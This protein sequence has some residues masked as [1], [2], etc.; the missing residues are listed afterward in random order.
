MSQPTPGSRSAFT[1][2]ELL[3][4][5]AIIATLVAI[6]LPAVQQAR[7]AARRSTCKNNLKQLGI[8]L[9]NYHD[10]YNTLPPGHVLD[11]FAGDDHGHWLWSAMILPFVEQSALYDTVRVGSPVTKAM[12]DSTRQMQQLLTVFRCPSDTGPPVFDPASRLGYTIDAIPTTGAT[13]NDI[14]VSLTNYA[15]SNGTAYPRAR[16]AT[17]Y[18][19]GTTGATG[20]FWENSRCKFSDITDGL[21]NTILVG[22]RAYLVK[23]DNMWGAMCL[24]IRGNLAA[25]NGPTAYDKSGNAAANQ[26]MFSYT[27]TTFFGINPIVSIFTGGTRD[28]ANSGYSSGHQGGAQFLLGDGAVIF[29]N[30]NIDNTGTGALPNG[31]TDSTFERLAAIQDGEVVGSF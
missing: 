3:V 23:G 22:E 25:G 20:A 13:L 27:G 31:I 8:A 29:L 10:T 9:H 26:G 11:P 19:N 24:A 17:N 16:K 2:I 4:V 1:L 28:I 6:L 12:G 30:E 18:I 15:V 21:S 14:P 7:E 5:I